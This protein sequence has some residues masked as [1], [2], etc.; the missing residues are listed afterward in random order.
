MPSFYLSSKRCS[1]GRDVLKPHY[2]LAVTKSKSSSKVRCNLCFAKYTTFIPR[3]ALLFSVSIQPD[4]T[5]QGMF[6]SSSR[7]APLSGRPPKKR[8]IA[9]VPHNEKK[10]HWWLYIYNILVMY[11][12]K[13]N[14]CFISKF[15]SLYI[16]ETC[17]ICTFSF[18]KSVMLSEFH[19]P[20]PSF[21]FLKHSL[22]S[23]KL[24]L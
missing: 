10:N 23:V 13:R 4:E 12:T 1:S 16:R 24:S 3:T 6:V 11:L 20:H 22:H 2:Y 7:Y 15:T 9:F 21:F 8:K 19:A 5:Y 18:V 17:D 14:L